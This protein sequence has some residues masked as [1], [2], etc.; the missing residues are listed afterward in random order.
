MTSLKLFMLMLGGRPAGRHI[1]QHDI[2]FGIGE[3]PKD[4]VFY[5][6][7]F[8]PEAKSGLHVDAWREVTHVDGYTIQV[9]SRDDCN[10]ENK[11]F[12]INLG[13]YQQGLFDEPHFKVLTVQ[14]NKAAA[15]KQAKNTNF[16][17]QVQFK[18]AKSHIDNK[19][20]VDIDDIHDIS[21]IL[22]A[23]QKAKYMLKITQ[24]ETTCE[25]EFHLGYFKLN[26][27]P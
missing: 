7:S 12:F 9:T 23:A 18:G 21:E 15:I 27:L 13:G 3:T 11:L 1:E 8:W 5:I 2:F 24:A 14:K 17:H 22:P 4:L 6:K 19:F 20:G 16:Y 26:T 25:N 10:E